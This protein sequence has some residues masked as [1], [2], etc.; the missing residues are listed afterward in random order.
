MSDT[1]LLKEACV[2]KTAARHHTNNGSGRVLVAVD[3]CKGSCCLRRC[4]D[5]YFPGAAT[6][7]DGTA[8]GLMGR[9][10]QL[11]TQLFSVLCKYVS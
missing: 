1:A 6:L 9:C 10:V 2:R 8:C 11:H 3:G 4:S 5:V 7:A